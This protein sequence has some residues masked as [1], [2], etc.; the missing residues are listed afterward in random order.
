[1]TPQTALPSR[2]TPHVGGFVL[3]AIPAVL[4]LPLFV[5]WEWLPL[6]ARPTFGAVYFFSGLAALPIGAIAPIVWLVSVGRGTVTWAKTVVAVVACACAVV[7]FGR[8]SYW[9]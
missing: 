6:A 5:G 3:L 1:M 7:A 2:K 9:F 4:Y 8:F